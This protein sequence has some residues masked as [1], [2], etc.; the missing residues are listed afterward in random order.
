M[1]ARHFLAKYAKEFSLPAKEISPAA[2]QKLLAYDWPGNVR[3]LENIIERAL[4]FSEQSLINCDDIYLPGTPPPAK[5]L[6]FKALKAQAIAEFE[7]AYLRRMLTLNDWNI[8]EA[9]RAAQK[10]RRAFW[11]LMR[12]HDIAGQ[13]SA[14]V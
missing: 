7:T 6:S 1:L 13:S 11:Q 5:E 4:V 14:R 8:S 3:E 10:N 9:A 2:L 12:K